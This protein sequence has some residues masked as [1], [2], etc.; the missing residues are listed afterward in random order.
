MQQGGVKERF[1]IIHK[2]SLAL[3][4]GVEFIEPNS[5]ALLSFGTSGTISI[6]LE[7]DIR[8]TSV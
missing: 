4:G 6:P 7:G 2:L 5:G 8:M 3:L 1:S